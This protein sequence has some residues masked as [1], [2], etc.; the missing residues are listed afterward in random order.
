MSHYCVCGALMTFVDYFAT[1]AHYRCNSCS[2]TAEVKGQ[3]TMLFHDEVDT[4]RNFRQL[5]N[6][7][8]RDPTNQRVPFQC[9]ACHMSYMSFLLAGQE[10]KP[11]V[12]CRCGKIYRIDQ[13]VIREVA[14]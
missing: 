10:E 2:A 9:N 13:S 3:N 4:G 11:Y 6:S 8:S 12:A 7:L 1:P 5:L 14:A